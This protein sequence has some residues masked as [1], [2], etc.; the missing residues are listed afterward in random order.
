[1]SNFERCAEIHYT[2]REAKIHGATIE[3]LYATLT[4]YSLSIKIAL[5]LLSKEKKIHYALILASHPTRLQC[6]IALPKQKVH[7]PSSQQPSQINTQHTKIRA[8]S[9]VHTFNPP[10]QSSMSL[11]RTPKE[12]THSTVLT[13]KRPVF[14]DISPSPHRP[15]FLA[16]MMTRSLSGIPLFHLDTSQGRYYAGNYPRKSVYAGTAFLGTFYEWHI[17]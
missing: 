4:A 11:S 9:S 10:K 2:C 16:N 12:K 1:M 15:S 7:Y 8:K 3:I 6:A 14:A 13:H 17:F 5:Y